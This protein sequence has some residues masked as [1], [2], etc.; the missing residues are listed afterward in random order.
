MLELVHR[1]KAAGD[2]DGAA[3]ALERAAERLEPDRVMALARDLSER[4]ARAGNLR[5]GAQL[6]ERLRART[7]ADERV[8]RPLLAYYTELQDGEAVERLIGETLPL[9]PEVGQRNELRMARARFVLAGDDRSPAAAEALRD[10]LMEEPGHAEALRLLAD[11]YT[12]TDAEG[13]LADLL[14]QRFEAA[15]QAQDREMIVEIA[16]RL[17]DLLERSDGGRAGALY[18]RALAL[19]PGRRELI[20][21]VLA[22]TPASELSRD[23]LVTMEELLAV[24]EG[25]AAAALARELADAWTK[26][27]DQEGARR[28]LE[29]GCALVPTDQELTE[30]LEGWYRDHE[31]WGP[32]AELLAAEAG[33]ETDTAEAAALLGE[34][35][36]LRGERLGDYDG[37]VA[38]LRQ[39][40]EHAPEDHQLVVQLARALTFSGQ[41]PAAIVEVK[42]GLEGMEPAD[43]NR[44]ALLVLLAELEGARGDTRAAVTTL[45]QAYATW[46]EAARV[47]YAAALAAWRDDAAFGRDAQAVRESTLVLAKFLRGDGELAQAL[48][49]LEELLDDGRPDVEVARLAAELAEMTEDLERALACSRRLVEME[50]GDARVDAILHVAG[51]GERLGRPADAAAAL[52]AALAAA[53]GEPRLFAALAELYERAGE[54]RKLAHLTF[55]RANRVADDGERFELLTRAGA[56]LVEAGEGSVAM[57]AI[58]EALAMRP[59]DE[60]LTLLLSD[61]Y[62]LAGA[63]DE[64]ADLLKPLLAAHKGKASPALAALYLRLARIAARAQDTK[65]ELEALARAL[66]ADKRNG[67]L[68]AEVA[69]RAEA[70]GDD[71][72]ALRALRAITLHAVGGPVTN[73]SSFLRQAKIVKRRGDNGRAMLLARRAAQEAAQNDPQALAESREF[74]ETIPAK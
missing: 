11:Y 26:L 31:A 2:F 56:L 48:Q 41:L 17:G 62:A 19:V 18:G 38:L 71:E 10:V 53:P 3:Q 20:R 33:R 63:M 43:D 16:L 45:A 52:E 44:L 66:D 24:E 68:A 23:R 54:Q 64:A 42:K 37:A 6:L 58:N 59:G 55:D 22:Q 21:R 5:L 28:V 51:L 61:A 15:A 46:P 40:R 74:L 29:K 70:V 1:R 47:P 8:W 67:A 30:R 36:T 7:P 60:G 39:A 65:A 57:M 25:P 12:R 50:E 32:L 73:A 34:A 69:D 13:D 35:A 14:E 9:L 4:A 49:L 27:E 72:M